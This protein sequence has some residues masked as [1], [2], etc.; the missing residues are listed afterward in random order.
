MW[1]ICVEVKDKKTGASVRKLEP[2]FFETRQ[3]VDTYLL[4]ECAIADRSGHYAVASLS[5]PTY[6]YANCDPTQWDLIHM[7]K[8]NRYAKVS[9]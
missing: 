6:G 2:K 4:S 7:S 9:A 5:H 3:L 8:A 1:R